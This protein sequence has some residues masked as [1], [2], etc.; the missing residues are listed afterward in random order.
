M[1]VVGAASIRRVGGFG[2]AGGAGGAVA[3]VVDEVAG[4][5]GAVADEGAAGGKL[6]VDGDGRDVDAVAGEPVEVDAAEIV[7]A[8]AGDHAAGLAELGH[9][10]DEDRRRAGGEGADER[11]RL[12]EAVAGLG[13]HDLDEDLADGDDLLHRARHVR[14][15]ARRSYGSVW[16]Y[17]W[18]RA[19]SGVCRAAVAAIC[20]RRCA[21]CCFACFPPVGG[22]PALQFQGRTLVW[23]GTP[24]R[25][26]SG[27][28]M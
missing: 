23:Q 9:L 8:D 20:A 24:G 26:G 15:Q 6:G 13:G 25:A 14:E 12:E 3:D 11:D 7:V 2:R 19:G 27:V 4:A 18:A 1:Q 21:R 22:D 10:V 28:T 5:V 16:T 17:V